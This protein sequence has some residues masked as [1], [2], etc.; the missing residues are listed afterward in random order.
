[1]LLTILTYLF[2]GGFIMGFYVWLIKKSGSGWGWFA[3]G[4]ASSAVLNFMT[5]DYIWG[6]LMVVL[7]FLYY[8]WYKNDKEGD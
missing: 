4:T 3:I 8:K 6:G 5:H 2:Y 7:T 1:M